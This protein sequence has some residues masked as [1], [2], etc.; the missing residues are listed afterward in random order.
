LFYPIDNHVD[1]KYKDLIKKG[2]NVYLIPLNSI[3]INYAGG[4]TIGHSKILS[5]L[6]NEN[7]SNKIAHKL[8]EITE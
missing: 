2:A 3:N 8:F 4:T 1:Y 7:D 5:K 6:I